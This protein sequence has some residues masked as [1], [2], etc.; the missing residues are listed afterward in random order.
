MATL[1]PSGQIQFIDSNGNPLVGGTIDFY[2]PNTTT[3]KTTWQ[4]S[5]QVTP[6]TNPIILDAAGRA[7]IY[8]SG[9]YR[10]VLKDSSGVTIYDQ[11]TASTDVGGLAW[12]GVSTGSANA[13]TIANSSF[14]QQDGQVIGFIAGFT[15]SSQLTVNGIP[16]LLDTTTGPQPLAGG[17]VV[18]QNSV[19]LTYQ[20]SRGAFLMATAAQVGGSPGT[21]PDNI[22]RVTGSA[23][24]TKKVALEVDGLTTGTTRTWTAQDASGTVAFM[25]N[26]TAAGA[27]QLTRTSTTVVTLVPFKGNLVS[28][29]SGTIATISSAGVAATITNCFVNGASGQTLSATTLYYVYLFLN[30]GTPTLDFSTT[31]HATDTTTGIEIKSGDATRVLVGMVYPQAGPVFSDSLTARLVASWF[32]RKPKK[33]ANSF[34]TTRSTTSGTYVEIN[35]EIRVNFVSWG[36]A[37]QLSYTG[38]ASALSGADS[39]FSAPS[40]DG[41]ITGTDFFPTSAANTGSGVATSGTCLPGEGF[42]YATMVGRIGASTGNWAVTFGG[43]ILSALLVS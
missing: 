42:H 4:D 17:E 31:G 33:L 39:V 12:G 41:A 19:S 11:L 25:G 18:A 3:R 16:V 36:D 28:F 2:T 7:I 40:L 8:G 13:Q 24:A 43:S 34:T 22:F 38:T 21:F 26:I 6:N 35:T 32:N 14:S 30:A 1:L 9:S 37:V 15:N 20:S 29:P 10:M 5:G 23:D 27:V